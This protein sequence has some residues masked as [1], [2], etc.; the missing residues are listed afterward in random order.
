MADEPQNSDRQ[1]LL[2]AAQS[3]LCQNARTAARVLTRFYDRY[4]AGTGIEPTQFNLLVAIRLMEPV[5]LVR[6]ADRLALERT[7]LT[8][9]L[10]ILQ[11]K[12]IVQ[13][14]TGADARKR[15]LS[16]TPLGR[17]LLKRSLSRWKEAQQAAISA[18]GNENSKKFSDAFSLIN[19]LNLKG[20]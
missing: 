18:L 12:G 3:C 7:T 14:A 2:E 5:S 20:D 16:L 15:L 19:K 17:T 1:A 4:F 10:A 6:L 9:N 13:I 8:R 11:R